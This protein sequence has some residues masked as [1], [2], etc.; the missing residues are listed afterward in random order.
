MI[1]LFICCLLD[2]TS[3]WVVLPVWSFIF[4]GPLVQ[5]KIEVSSL[6]PEYVIKPGK[7]RFPIGLPADWQSLIG[8]LCSNQADQ[9]HF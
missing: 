1:G 4:S 9:L 7:L 5:A 3:S 6:A 8:R 2:L